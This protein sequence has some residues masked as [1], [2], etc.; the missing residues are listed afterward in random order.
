MPTNS[1]L[2]IFAVIFVICAIFAVAIRIFN[3]PKS[4]DTCL[5]LEKSCD[6]NKHCCDPLICNQGKCS[7]DKG[8]AGEKCQYSEINCS[9]AGFPESCNSND[10]NCIDQQYYCKCNPGYTGANCQYKPVPEVFL[11]SKGKYYYSLDFT[12]AQKLAAD[13]GGTLATPQQLIDSQKAGSQWCLT[14]WLSDQSQEFPMQIVKEGCG[15][16]GIN[17]YSVPVGT[18][19]ISKSAVNIY[20]IKPPQGKYPLACD[21]SNDSETPCVYRFYNN[22]GNKEDITPNK[23]SQFD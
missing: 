4:N 8:T 14:G 6:L 23:Y 9:G 10:T 22:Q 16:K 18:D 15:V 5:G 3:N 2:K 11:A 17:D 1:V 13:L 7:C 21:S 12:E 20:G 19:G